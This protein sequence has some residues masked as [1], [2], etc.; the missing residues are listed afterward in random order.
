MK[1]KNLFIIGAVIIAAIFY[2]KNAK[3]KKLKDLP[4]SP[5]L[6]PPPVDNKF[7]IDMIAVGFNYP[8]PTYEG[9]RAQGLDTQYLIKDGVKYGITFDQWVRRNYDPGIPVDQSILNLIPDGGIL[10]ENLV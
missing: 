5:I 9:M 8:N 7:P 4:V 10:P 6:P 2:F 3:A 1:N